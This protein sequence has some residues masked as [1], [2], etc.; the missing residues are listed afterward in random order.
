MKKHTLKYLSGIIL[1]SLALTAAVTTANGLRNTPVEVAAEGE[2]VSSQLSN[3][4]VAEAVPFQVDAALLGTVGIEWGATGTFTETFATEDKNILAD[5]ETTTTNPVIDIMFLLQ[6][7][8]GDGVTGYV[9]L[10]NTLVFTTQHTISATVASNVLS[11]AGEMGVG[12]RSTGTLSGNQLQLTSERIAY[13]T[14][15]GEEVQRQFR[16][17]A[18]ANPGS[19]L[20]IGEYRETVWGLTLQPLTIGGSFSL[21]DSK[22]P[23]RSVN[24]PPVAEGQ[25]VNMMANRSQAITL[26]GSDAD[27]ADTLTYTVMSDPVNGSLSGTA[28]NLTYTPNAFFSGSDS[29]TFSVNDGTVES[30]AASV[31]IKVES[32]GTTPEPT[33]T[34]EP[35]SSSDQKVYLPIISGMRQTP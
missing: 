29:F 35:P 15:S 12:P 27:N 11:P 19:G 16:L 25:T 22:V 7:E 2:S 31:T 28:P 8:A 33:E 13:Q 23:E 18:S 6:K 3:A 14:E 17:T 30:A 5:G 1:I 21:V 20:I 9:E 10:G 34:P 24:Q 32:D 26:T 4:P